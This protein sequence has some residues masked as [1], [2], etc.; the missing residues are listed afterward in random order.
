M[1]IL[2]TKILNAFGGRDQKL[3]VLCEESGFKVLDQEKT[4]V[5]VAWAEVLEVFAYKEDRFTYDDICIGFRVSEHG[6]FWMV[7]EDF[8]GYETLL[9]ELERRFSG[10]RMDWFTDVGFPAFATNR[11]TL[12]G[13]RWEQG[14]K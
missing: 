10:I 12:W 8:V 13:T 6:T 14:N 4:L 3:K 1:K 5:H 2:K 9:A 7:S 11:T